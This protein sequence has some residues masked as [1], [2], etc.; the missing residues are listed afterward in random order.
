M[1]WLQ[2]IVINNN[3]INIL[4]LCIK[5]KRILQKS[6]NYTHFICFQY[7]CRKN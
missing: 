6:S 7:F 2:L 5:N 4:Y 3:L 1:T